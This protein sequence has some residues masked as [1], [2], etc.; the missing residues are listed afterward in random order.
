MISASDTGTGS[1]NVPVVVI[2]APPAPV[3]PPPPQPPP[4]PPPPVPVVPPG[5][6]WEQWKAVIMSLIATGLTGP[7]AVERHPL[8]VNPGTDILLAFMATWPQSTTPIGDVNAGVITGP[9][10]I[11]LTG[12]EDF[13]E[14]GSDPTAYDGWD[15]EPFFGEGGGLSVEEADAKILRGNAFVAYTRQRCAAHNIDAL[16]AFANAMAEGLSGGI[17]DQGRAYG[18]WQIWAADGRI[19]AFAGMPPYAPHIQGWAWSGNG[20]EYAIRSMVAGGAKG[21]RG[22]AAVHAIVYGFEKPSDKAGA[23]TIRSHNY[24][25]L[26][27][28]GSGAD[29]YLAGIA[30]GPSLSVT[31]SGGGTTDTSPS[32]TKPVAN[33]TTVKA[34]KELMGFFAHDMPFAA[35]HTRTLSGNL[36]NVFK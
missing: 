6:T 22:H 11:T 24:D 7:Q 8:A 23:Y 3:M 28:K 34:W 18:P 2:P 16:A 15:Y 25:L 31:P 1:A 5:E 14:P 29:A 10:I 35:N 17:G 26:L 13:G 9:P 12:G 30:D 4:P 33:V 32:T 36:I 20:I 27:A 21:L 19:Q